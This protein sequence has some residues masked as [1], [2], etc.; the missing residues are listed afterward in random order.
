M[1]KRAV[2]TRMYLIYFI[3]FF[4]YI[5]NKHSK[6]L[7]MSL[8]VVSESCQSKSLK[9]ILVALKMSRQLRRQ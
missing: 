9:K 4:I 2:L 6:S 1:M 5:C 7:A 8:E 3:F